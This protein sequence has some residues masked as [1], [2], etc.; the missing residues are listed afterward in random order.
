MW[1]L[2]LWGGCV[3][4][5]VVKAVKEELGLGPRGLHVLS[6][7][8][9]LVC[10]ANVDAVLVVDLK[11]G[12]VVGKILLH[13]SENNN[14]VTAWMDPN[15]LATCLDCSYLYV[16]GI[17]G[18]HDDDSHH[19]HRVHK[20]QLPSSWQE[21]VDTNDFSALSQIDPS[22]DIT[23][24][25]VHHE[26]DGPPHTI[27]MAQDGSVAY[28]VHPDSG[29]WKI[30]PDSAQDAS[31]STSTATP[32]MDLATLGT[33]GVLEGAFLTVN[34]EKLVVTSQAAELVVID[35]AK[36]KVIERRLLLVDTHC[37]GDNLDLESWVGSVEGSHAYAFYSSRTYSE[38]EESK[39]GVPRGWAL[40][41]M[42]LSP[43]ESLSSGDDND[44]DN[45]DRDDTKCVK[46][47][48]DESD[49]PGWRDGA[50]T[51]SRF[52]RPTDIQILEETTD[53]V[54][55]IASDIDNR[56]L[57]VIDWRS[58]VKGGKEKTIATVYSVD[59][60]DDLWNQ[61]HQ[62]EPNEMKFVSR[63]EADGTTA[64]A[65]DFADNSMFLLT[66]EEMPSTLS[67]QEMMQACQ[68]V[69]TQ[70]RVCDAKE[71]RI[72]LD[73]VFTELTGQSLTLWTGTSCHSCWLKH[74]GHCPALADYNATATWGPEYFKESSFGWGWEFYMTAHIYK[75]HYE[76][77]DTYTNMQT[78]CLHQDTKLNDIAKNGHEIIGMCCVD[79][80]TSQ[81]P[82]GN[83]AL[84]VT[85][86]V[87]GL[88]LG[89]IVGVY[90]VS[91]YR[92]RYRRLHGNF[93]RNTDLSMKS[94]Y[95]DDGRM[96]KRWQERQ[97][98]NDQL[99]NIHLGTTDDLYGVQSTGS[100]IKGDVERS[101]TNSTV[102]N[103]KSESL[104]VDDFLELFVDED[105]DRRKKFKKKKSSRS[106]SGRRKSKLTSDSRQNRDEDDQSA[107]S[108]T[109]A[110]SNSINDLMGHQ[111]N[112]NSD[113]EL[114]PRAI[115]AKV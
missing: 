87:A 40:Y 99:H 105:L 22:N 18:V 56:A 113:V 102:S 110:H 82:D 78:T 26:T 23:H 25:K 91:Y 38:D 42:A 67:Y 86:L 34:E 92:G 98:R 69:H 9:V 7:R 13:S 83:D 8:Y 111:E 1:L 36:D 14:N 24:V 95:F 57:R 63:L 108:A 12:G 97:L 41:K 90:I 2:L 5:V 39:D 106:L 16:V 80:I 89:L 43:S 71:I 79:P 47:A 29:V 51:E 49:L 66:V 73:S 62:P 64:L 84:K 114:S 52:S 100:G 93:G 3:L 11:L 55:L 115:L 112:Q 81:Q 54:R 17:Q 32:Y 53:S 27:V 88:L 37:V 30:K 94:I 101:T 75:H 72:Q 4:S 96:Q 48:G 21:M 68:V 50:P 107:T 19:L 70:A 58:L 85:G 77:V 28:M 59:Y 10:E 44:N 65:E 109:S 74:P 60:N 61:I 6:E 15:F 46:L 76:T 45:D 103:L 33:M 20:V 31:S 104:K 35:L